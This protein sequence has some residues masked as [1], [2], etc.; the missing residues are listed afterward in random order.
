MKRTK[1]C[2]LCRYYE[3]NVNFCAV[4]PDYIGKSH[5]CADFELGI[6]LDDDDDDDIDLIQFIYE[7]L[8]KHYLEKLLSPYGE[9]EVGRTFNTS[10]KR[11]I[12]LWF[13]PKVSPLPTELGLLARLAKTRALFEPYYYPITPDDVRASLFKLLEVHGEFYRS[14]KREKV[15]LADLDLPWLWILTPTASE[16]ILRAFAAEEKKDKQ[17]GI[18]FMAPSFLTGLVVIDQLPETSETLCLRLLGAERVRHQALLELEALPVNHS[19]R[20]IAL[21]LLSNFPKAN[22]KR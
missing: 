2:G 9:V 12:D 8:S 17:T 10:P 1:T 20:S 5:L 19:L 22:G 11:E 6:E 7:Q 15:Q 4:A 13:A 21:E 14:A 18:Y 16:T 3:I